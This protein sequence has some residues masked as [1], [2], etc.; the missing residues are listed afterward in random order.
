MDAPQ[1][2]T[3]E[4]V[5]RQA[6]DLTRD[7]QQRVTQ[8]LAALLGEDGATAVP[9][10]P[11]APAT[12]GQ[13]EG[14][15]DQWLDDIATLPAWERLRLMD[16]ALLRTEPGEDTDAVQRA[17]QLLLDN[18]PPLAVRSSVTRLVEEHPMMAALGGLGLVFGLVALLRRLFYL[19][20]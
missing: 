19:I 12:E 3:V 15:V 7:E 2:P 16:D 20:F 5:I 8:V 18:N 1:P 9:V 11:I 10:A 13:P 6:L 4:G 14:T 17:R